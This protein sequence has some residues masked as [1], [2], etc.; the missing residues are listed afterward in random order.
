MDRAG[1]IEKWRP[2]F[3]ALGVQL[4][5]IRPYKEAQNSE[6]GFHTV[7]PIVAFCCDPNHTCRS[8]NCLF[9]VYIQEQK[10]ERDSYV[11]RKNDQDY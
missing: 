1:P 7:S 10:K 11:K 5:R 9:L 4:Y 8:A 3:Y 6:A 2:A